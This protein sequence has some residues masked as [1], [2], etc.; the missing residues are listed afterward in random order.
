[1]KDVKR[2]YLGTAILVSLPD[3]LRTRR[4]PSWVTALTC[5]ELSFGK[6]FKRKN[7]FL[8]NTLR[9]WFTTLLKKLV[10]VLLQSMNKDVKSSRKVSPLA[11]GLTPPV[12]PSSSFTSMIVSISQQS[13]LSSAFLLLSCSKVCMSLVIFLHLSIQLSLQYTLLS[14]FSSRIT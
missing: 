5:P 7:E 3:S 1:M 6:L 9:V 2:V 14:T 10:L 11:P 13:E 4:I 8:C 12:S